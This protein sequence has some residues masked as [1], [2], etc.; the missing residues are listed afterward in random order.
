VRFQTGLG[1]TLESAV[2]ALDGE[3]LV[4]QAR[5][6]AFRTS[7]TK[8]EPYAVQ[9][10]LAKDLEAFVDA[11][12]RKYPTVFKANARPVL[13]ASR[14]HDWADGLREFD[15]MLRDWGLG[16]GDKPIPVVLAGSA[17]QTGGRFLDETYERSAETQA[18]S[19]SL[20]EFTPAEAVV[21]YQWVLLY[22]WDKAAADPR[23]Q[24]AYVPRTT[25]AQVEWDGKML[26]SLSPYLPSRVDHDLYVAACSNKS[27]FTDDD[28]E[29]VLAR[30]MESKGS[31]AAGARGG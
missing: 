27:L 26:D 21:A 18:R 23:K 7:T 25:Q 30:F 20:T 14:V 24:R 3:P 12:R 22:P 29:A 4:N 17:G 31:R 15:M 11:A 19:V 9:P 13:L 28:D 8:L 10:E 6:E 2:L 16:D 1:T 5:L